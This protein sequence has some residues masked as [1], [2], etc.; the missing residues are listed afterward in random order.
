MIIDEDFDS[1]T[2]RYDLVLLPMLQELS[3]AR[4]FCELLTQ[5][6]DKLD[7]L[8]DV[9]QYDILW[10]L[11]RFHSCFQCA[12]FIEFNKL[13]FIDKPDGKL[14]EM[15]FD[16]YDKLLEQFKHYSDII[17]DIIY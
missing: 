13:S 1:T 16:E 17:E 3:N 9:D 14:R 7:I 4:K 12:T 8:Q 11:E 2:S 10:A 6:I 15:F 5:N